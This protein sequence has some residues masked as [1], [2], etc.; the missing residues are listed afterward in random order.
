[1]AGRSPH[2]CGFG[3]P[4]GS[5]HPHPHPHPRSFSS[6]HRIPFETGGGGFLWTTT[7]GTVDD[8]GRPVDL[9]ADFRPPPPPNSPNCPT[10]CSTGQLQ[11]R[12][13]I[14]ARSLA[15][16]LTLS[17]LPNAGGRAAGLLP[18]DSQL[19]MRTAGFVFLVSP[20][21]R[22]FVLFGQKKL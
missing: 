3:S 14:L 20:P 19:W 5:P 7:A 16:S 22:R 17:S 1:M 8:V 10:P 18:S 9:Y 15:Q 2:R 21:W 4:A 11:S 12:P 13:H 6:V